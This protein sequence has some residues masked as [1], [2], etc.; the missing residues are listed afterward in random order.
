MRIRG[1]GIHV[2]CAPQRSFDVTHGLRLHV[3][4][5]GP[6][7]T[8]SGLDCYPVLV[9]PLANTRIAEHAVL[10]AARVVEQELGLDHRGQDTCIDGARRAQDRQEGGGI[11]VRY[12]DAVALDVTVLGRLDPDVGD[13]EAASADDDLFNAPSLPNRSGYKVEPSV[14]QPQDEGGPAG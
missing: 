10:T 7:P 11:G 2:E 1:V 5:I 3:G 4:D 6:K 8:E 9:A 12:V 13:S 14:T